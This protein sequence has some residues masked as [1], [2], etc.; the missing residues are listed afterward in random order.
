MPTVPVRLLKRGRYR[1]CIEDGPRGTH[2]TIGAVVGDCSIE[3]AADLIASRAAAL[4]V[5]P[6]PNDAEFLD[7]R[8]PNSNRQRSLRRRDARDAMIRNYFISQPRQ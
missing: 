1:L 4:H 6:I 2:R 7:T 8:H 5:G 3:V